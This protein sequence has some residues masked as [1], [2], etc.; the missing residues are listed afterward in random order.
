[1]ADK[2]NLQIAGVIENMS[3]FTAPDGQRYPIFGEGGGRQLADELEVPLLAQVPLTMPLRAQADAGVPP[4]AVDPD[5]AAAQA[6]AHAARGLLALAK[7]V[8]FELPVLDVIQTVP[9]K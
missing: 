5:D 9:P 7:P 1:M 8:P 2:V 3:G 4:V 6:I